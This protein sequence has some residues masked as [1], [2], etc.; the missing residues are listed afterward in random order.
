MRTRAQLIRK[1][2]KMRKNPTRAE[3][4]LWSKLRRR[5]LK[6]KKFRR[7]HVLRPYIVDFYCFSQCLVVEVDGPPHARQERQRHD[8]RRD[9]FL[10]RCHRVDRILR[11]EQSRVLDDLQGV[12]GAIRRVF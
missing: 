6:G 2:R 5:Q 11:F 1:A 7:Q 8:E 3:A 12:V 4:L 9:Q 10:K